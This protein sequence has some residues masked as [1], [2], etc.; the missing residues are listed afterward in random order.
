MDIRY[1]IHP[2][3]G[4][5]LDTK[6]LRKEFLIEKPFK[7]GEISFTYSHIDR[8]IVGSAV[9]LDHTLTLEAG[10]ELRAEYFLERR[11]MGIINIG[12]AGVL[13]LDDKALPLGPRDGIYVGMGTKEVAFSSEDAKNPAKFY[14]ASAPAHRSYPTKLVSLEK[15]VKVE[16][17]SK[18]ESNKR[19]IYQFIHPAVLESCQLVMGMTLLEPENVWNTMP[20]HTH[21]RRMEVYLY[22]DMDP[23]T[24]VFH[25]CGAPDE[26][27]HII[28]NNEQ[29]V[30]SPSWSIHAGVGTS[31]YTFIWAMVGENKTFTDMDHVS[32]E[33]MR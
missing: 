22:F 10:E 16:M 1:G 30:I 33:E 6:G 25:L 2:D 7:P 20:A 18:K 26:T 23:N 11:E 8:I 29:A 32:M 14:I 9:P 5:Q 3:H 27:R 4:K 31:N 28:M 24:R 21:E 15:A 12:G 19:C 17:G 13:T